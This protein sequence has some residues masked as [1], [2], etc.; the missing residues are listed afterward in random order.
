MLKYLKLKH[1]LIVEDGK[2]K[3]KNQNIFDDLIMTCHSLTKLEIKGTLY[4]SIIFS[5]EIFNFLHRNMMFD[6]EFSLNFRYRIEVLISNWNHA[7]Q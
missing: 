1:P 4:L 7:K 2:F 6:T 3:D 5:F